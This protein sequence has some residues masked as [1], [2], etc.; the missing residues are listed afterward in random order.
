MGVRRVDLDAVDAGLLH[1]H[2]RIAELAGEF[3]DLVDGDGT[4]RLAGVGRAHEGRGDEAR[5]AGHVERHVGGVEQLRHDLGTVLVHGGVQLLPTGDEGVVIAAHVTGQ[6]G[7]G[8]STV[9]TSVMMRPTPP[10]ARAV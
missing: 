4:R 7:I 6:V 10:L 3:V 8:G 9:T 2:G 1:A 5:R